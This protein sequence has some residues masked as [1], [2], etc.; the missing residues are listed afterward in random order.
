MSDVR[1]ALRAL[2]RQLLFTLVA[3]LTL[4]LGIGANTAIFSFLYHSALRPLPF[5]N[6]DRLVFVWNTYPLMGLPLASVSIP[7]YLDRRAQADAIE[8]AT[9]V[10]GRNVNLSIDGRPE[11]ARG[12][13]AT[14]SF[15]TTLGR[16]PVI[17]APFG[18]AHDEPGNDEAVVLSHALWRTRFGADPAIVGR[19]IRVDG[20]PH[21]VLG[22]MP[23]DFE[24]PFTEIDLFLPF[25]FTPEQRSDQE[26]GREFSSMVAR[27]RPG[28][29]IEQLDAQMK[30][31]VQ[32]NLERL[33]S[34]RAFAETSGFSGFAVDYREQVVG[35]ILPALYLLQGAVLVLLLIA[36][37]NVANLLLMRATGR[38]RE[39]AIRHTLGANVWRLVR[40]LLAEGIV[41]AVIGALVGIA[42][43]VVGV[44]ALAALAADQLPGSSSVGVHAPTLAFTA[45]LALLTGVVFGLTPALA[46][47][48]G[49]TSELVN[50]EG[51]RTS[52]S[53]A[54]SYT[55][56]ALVVAETALAVVLLVGAGL[57]ARSFARL[58]D[59][60]PGFNK[61]NVFT[62]HLSLPDSRY[63]DEA[64]R[65]AFWARLATGLAETTGIER[66]G[67]VSNV[68]LSGN[69][70]SGSYGIVGYTVPEGEAQPH[71]RIVVVGGDYFGAMQIP[72]LKGRLLSSS[73]TAE[74]QRVVVV[75]E[76]LVSRYF[77]DEDPL[78]QQIRR[79]GPD[80]PA[81]TIVGVVGTVNG[82]DLSEPVTKETL[83]FPVAQSP[84][85]TM[86]IIARTTGEPAALAP[87]V[88]ALVTRFDPEQPVHD[89]RA[90]DE[91][92][93]RSLNTRQAPMLLLVAFGVVALAL[94]AVGLYGVLAFAVGQRVREIGVRQALGAARGD[95]MTMVLGQ[96]MR[97][98]GLG[99]ATGL[100]AAVVVARYLEAQLFGI[101]AYDRVVYASVA[102]V[103][104][105]VA[106]LACCVPARRATRIE[107]MEA[108]RE[109]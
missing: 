3:V 2:L 92:V 18:A 74:S 78:G 85:R 107:P 50:D 6:G 24:T 72:L 31:I 103:L 4:A 26:R 102:L 83:Y 19:D 44:R 48:R 59:V 66:V 28:A 71:G 21:R 52:S 90:L 15:F 70:G 57:L 100:V 38:H 9:L 77:K 36:C 105:A 25:A 1:Y 75:D 39:L 98:A 97:T 47:A 11:R 76:L 63:P 65:R 8:D 22:V 17:G 93:A 27:L 82:I 88:R 10:T 46:V 55:R 51:T 29:T 96:G 87:Q 81:W 33:P 62:A 60:D 34:A 13:R 91:W 58:Q 40:Q 84:Q 53:R 42:F 95:I 32:R 104:V 35:E 14:S 56:G 89:V 86:A 20:L 67:L 12:L 61:A 45:A 99:V 106:L 69:V 79:G 109:T 68:P 7:D 23:A 94:A 80:A 30:T 41:L 43:G 101:G 37:A 73:D 5:P 64:A 108:L 16:V 49:S 54:T